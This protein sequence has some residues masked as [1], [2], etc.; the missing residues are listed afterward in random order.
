MSRLRSRFELLLE[1]I[2]IALMVLL[3][4]EVTIGV[5]FRTF[6]L[7][8]AWYAWGRGVVVARRAL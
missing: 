7:A 8:R 3:S 5:R 6:G 2:V 1:W 4:A